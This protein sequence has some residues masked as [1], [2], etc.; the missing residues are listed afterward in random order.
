M[1]TKPCLPR[2]I[3]NTEAE[4]DAVALGIAQ[5]QSVGLG[6][7]AGVICLPD[8]KFETPEGFPLDLEH[9]QSALNITAFQ[10]INEQAQRHGGL[11]LDD[12]LEEGIAKTGLEPGGKSLEYLALCC[13]CR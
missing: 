13:Q 6:D 1:L 9:V 5:S 12:R 3:A 10:A 7:P 4:H 11:D 2:L 8:Q